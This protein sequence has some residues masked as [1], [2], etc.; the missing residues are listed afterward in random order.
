MKT[1]VLPLPAVKLAYDNCSKIEA[2]LRSLDGVA[3]AYMG[4]GYVKLSF[5]NYSAAVRNKAVLTLSKFM[6]SLALKKGKAVATYS[7][8]CIKPEKNADIDDE[9]KA[10]RRGALISLG[11]FML[12]EI[13]RRVSPAAYMSTRLLRSAAVFMM[14][15]QL[16]KN[17]VLGALRERRPNADTLTVTAVMASVIA[18]K[19]ESS[20]TLLTLSNCAE[21]LTTLAARKAR[22]NISKLV[23]L[24]V[25]DVWIIDDNGL[26]RKIPLEQV[27][28]GMVVTVHTGEKICV[29]GEV[30]AGEA[31][32]DQA[33]ITG[34]SVPAAK[35]KGDKAYAGTVVSLGELTIRVN[36]VGDDTSLARIV[37]MVEDASN[38]R[39]PVQNYADSMATALV[40]VSF[41]GAVIVYLATRDIQRVLNML[42]IDFSCGLKLSTAT[43]ISA[44][45]SRAAKSGILVKGGS[46]IEAASNIDTVILDKTGTITRGKPAIVNI[47]TAKDV[48]AE[49]ILKLAAS[50]EMHSS[51]PMAI[52][53]LDEVKK[54]KLEVPEHEDTQTVVA[55]GIRASI[56]AVDGF[57]G[58]EILVGSLTFMKE[59]NI[60]GIFEVKKVSPTGSFIYIS[61]AGKLLGVLEIDDPIRPEFKRAINR[62]RY[63][64]VEEINMLTGDNKDVA[65][66]IARDLGLDGY[67]AEVMPEDKAGFVAKAQSV[68]N[69][70]MVGDGINDAPALAYADVGVAMGTGCTDT[71][72]ESADVTIN[73]EDPL[74]LPEFIGIGKRT[75]QLVHQNFCATILINTSAMMLGSLG[76]ITPLWATVVH[77]AS[78]LGVVLN[79][80]RVLLEP[81]KGRNTQ[82]AA[83]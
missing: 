58:G 13:M 14:S 57:E 22:S 9:F 49:L 47:T 68:G 45:V 61:G 62:L 71:A 56:N 3:S 70:L 36:K 75:M 51:H 48:N 55:R 46:F 32:V 80:A 41:L 40:P 37:H 50:A 33:A 31:A 64:G 30:I 29:D 52:S 74:K 24:D 69:V 5:D 12:F 79:S 34:E 21:M 16:L 76:L 18:G 82:D 23:A 73:S 63:S 2:K 59:Q 83:N 67:R 60:S 10:H 8:E 19:P 28:E 72:M 81:K 4:E 78:T 38:R 25:R 66:A 6:G 15:S 43:A 20:L 27:K 39:A 44:A 77:N 54:R 1:V 65:A 17:G 26:E 35:K 11:C 42:F 7:K 53:I